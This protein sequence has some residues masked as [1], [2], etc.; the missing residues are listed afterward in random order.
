[1]LNNKPPTSVHP[2]CS[3]PS[4]QL[5]DVKTQEMKDGKKGKPIPIEVASN[6]QHNV[7]QNLSHLKLSKMSRNQIRFMARSVEMKAN[8]IRNFGG[9]YS[10]RPSSYRRGRQNGKTFNPSANIPSSF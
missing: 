5:P 8:K 9:F 10:N 4:Q 7:T 1:M 6:V 2:I 3:I